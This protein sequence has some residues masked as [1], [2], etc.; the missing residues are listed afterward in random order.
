[1]LG[2]KLCQVLSERF[3]VWGTVRKPNPAFN[4]SAVL[5]VH[6]IISGVDAADEDLLANVIGTV[7]P[8]V[9]INAIGIV[10]QITVGNDPASSILVNSLFPHWVAS[11]CR[12]AGA[13]LIHIST[14][15]VFSGTRGHY[16]EDDLPDP[17]DLY[18][19][20]KLLGEVTGPNVLTVRTSIVGRELQTSHG[21]VEWFLSSQG[22]SVKG[23]SRAVFSGLPTLELARA[24]RYV[25]DE[26]PALAGLYH[27]AASPID[28]YR[29]LLLLRD[30]YG[31]EI[32]IEP[33]E[34]YVL[35]RSLDGS[36]F[37]DATG[38]LAEPWDVLVG[39]MASDPTAY[40]HL[41]AARD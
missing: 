28:K 7:R 10:K 24:L 23:Y 33:Y 21:L 17:G 27:I 38:F 30:A 4:R 32:T 2:H 5:P 14:D 6:R 22:K 19:R 9:V 31:I 39:R 34:G 13:R 41:R 8:E 18:G 1:M 11:A 35:D 26:H 16:S 15:C 3:E 29:L 25:I 20:T 40:D 12:S 36:R 37:R